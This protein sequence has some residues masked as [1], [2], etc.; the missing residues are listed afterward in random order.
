MPREQSGEVEGGAGEKRGRG[1]Y[2]AKRRRKHVDI[3][4]MLIVNR[5][6]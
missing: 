1:K 5:E 4:E 6:S 2:S 3:D